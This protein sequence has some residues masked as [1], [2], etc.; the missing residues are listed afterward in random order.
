MLVPVLFW[1]AGPIADCHPKLYLANYDESEADSVSSKNCCQMPKSLKSL[2][3]FDIIILEIGVL[4]FRCTLIARL[5]VININ[6][7]PSPSK[8][9]KCQSNQGAR[10][11][12][13]NGIPRAEPLTQ[14]FVFA[15]HDACRICWRGSK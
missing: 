2:Q 8:R 11:H 14:L 13:Q 3:A 12:W 4:N 7:K 15:V 6:V 10:V 5:A 1:S 9:S